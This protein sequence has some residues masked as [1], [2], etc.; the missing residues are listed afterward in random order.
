MSHLY[1]AFVSDVSFVCPSH[2]GCRLAYANRVPVLQKYG[3]EREPLSP[4]QVNH[5]ANRSTSHCGVKDANRKL[6]KD[7]EEH[8][9]PP[10]LTSANVHPEE[11]FAPARKRPKTEPGDRDEVERVCHPEKK[12]KISTGMNFLDAPHHLHAILVFLCSSAF[13]AFI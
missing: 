10:I 9:V 1:P 3:G 6:T 5:D 13:Y 12:A 4:I 2:S 8:S 7:S 11:S